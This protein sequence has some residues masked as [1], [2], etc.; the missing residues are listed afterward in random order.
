MALVM[1]SVSIWLLT[2]LDMFVFFADLVGSR[3]R[4]YMIEAVGDVLT[5]TFG[6]PAL[7]LLRGSGTLG[8]MLALAALLTA[9]AVVTM[10]MRALV[11]AASRR[12]S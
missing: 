10:G 6:E 11:G 12:H 3:V 8:I 7:A 9:T 4:T 5:G 2:R 1:T